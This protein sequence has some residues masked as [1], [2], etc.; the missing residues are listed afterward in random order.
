M[1]ALLKDPTAELA[2]ILDG[3][4]GPGRAVDWEALHSHILAGGPLPAQWRGEGT[5]VGALL[6]DA[7][8]NATLFNTKIVMPDRYGRIYACATSSAIR[9]VTG[10]D[11]P[12]LQRGN[13]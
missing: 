12:P 6:S 2:A 11:L 8:G 7:A 3:T 9:R 10:D 5:A 4:R 1:S 13:P